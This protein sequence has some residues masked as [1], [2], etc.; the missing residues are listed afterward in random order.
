MELRA[1][2]LQRTGYHHYCALLTVCSTQNLQLPKWMSI[3][4]PCFNN[5]VH[6]SDSYVLFTYRPS[7]AHRGG[8]WIVDLVWGC[9]ILAMSHRLAWLLS[10]SRW[11]RWVSTLVEVTAYDHTLHEIDQK[12]WMSRS[13]WHAAPV[14]IQ[15]NKSHISLTTH[16]NF[17]I[18]P[19]D[20]PQVRAVEK[21]QMGGW[22][23]MGKSW[24][25]GGH[26]WETIHPI[27][28]KSGMQPICHSNRKLEIHL[29]KI[30]S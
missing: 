26:S 3:H 18:E 28:F 1:H 6:R 29:S 16:T 27:Y 19:K 8:L 17:R 21:F 7:Q 10:Q 11:S 14:K 12:T 23:S 20:F 15:S 2:I 24:I 30:S 22:A 9:L 25:M 5:D 13:K 4:A